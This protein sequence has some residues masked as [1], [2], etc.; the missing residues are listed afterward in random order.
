[1]RLGEF[2]TAARRRTGRASITVLKLKVGTPDN[3]ECPNLLVRSVCG[4]QRAR[5]RMV[6][7]K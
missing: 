2:L 3:A 6:L 7:V 4:W 1:M 5:C